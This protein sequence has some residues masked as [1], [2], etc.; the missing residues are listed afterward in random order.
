MG[1]RS[2]NEESATIENAEDDSVN[3][4][5][6]ND[7][8]EM[9]STADDSVSVDGLENYSRGVGSI[10]KLR[11]VEWRNGLRLVSSPNDDHGP[12]AWRV[13]TAIAEDEEE[14]QIRQSTQRGVKWD[15][16][17]LRYLDTAMNGV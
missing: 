7:G 3:G 11:R 6:A 4:H 16:L 14:T 10:D 17:P 5:T 8:E 1:H 15:Q 2:N 12:S 13:L 9:H